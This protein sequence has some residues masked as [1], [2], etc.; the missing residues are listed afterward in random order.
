MLTSTIIGPPVESCGCQANSPGA[1][2]SSPSTVGA[3]FVAFTGLVMVAA[4]AAPLDAG[5]AGTTWADLAAGAGP[6]GTDGFGVVAK[7]GTQAMA[8][9]R[10]AQARACDG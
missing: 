2:G 10:L 7:A 8:K 9:S 1:S 5:T 4:F 6:A 3:G